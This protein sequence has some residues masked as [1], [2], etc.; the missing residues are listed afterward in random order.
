MSVIVGYTSSWSYDQIPG[1]TI[2]AYGNSISGSNLYIN[3][4]DNGDG[5]YSYHF[6]LSGT[7]TTK[8]SF[9]VRNSLLPPQINNGMWFEFIIV[10][11]HSSSPQYTQTHND[12]LIY[13]GQVRVSISSAIEFMGATWSQNKQKWD[14]EYRMAGIS[15][16]A[17]VSN[18]N[19]RFS[20]ARILIKTTQNTSNIVLW[21]T[22]NNPQYIGCTPKPSTGTDYSGIATAVVGLAL[23]VNYWAS[24][25]WGSATA[26]VELL[27]S[28]INSSSDSSQTIERSWSWWPLIRDSCQFLWFDV[29]VEPNELVEFS[30]DYTIVGN[31][32]EVLGVKG[33]RQLYAGSPGSNLIM[34]PSLMSDA[35]REKCGIITITREDLLSGKK[36]K[37]LSER[38]INRLLDTKDKLFYFSKAFSEREVSYSEIPITNE[39]SIQEL[40][41]TEINKQIKKSELIIEAFRMNEKYDN[42][43]S[44]SIVE[45]HSTRM[46]LLQELQNKLNLSNNDS[47]EL[48]KILENYISIMNL[49][50]SMR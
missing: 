41:L 27:A 48:S 11:E 16:T 14:F 10:D 39:S 30:Y 44:K 46:S 7:P 31:P 3:K 19:D 2:S 26:I 25:I 36:N 5:T 22:P 24:L 49:D 28:V 9:L 45:K 21:P 20:Y 34:N 50:P 4:I 35:E 32:F 43:D 6:L 12:Q 17:N 13:G 18:I 33:Y 15:H 29:L 8:G 37:D 42:I 47:T 23:G 40:L 38:T 1:I